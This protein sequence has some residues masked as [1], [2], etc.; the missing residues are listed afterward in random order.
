[1]F[2]RQDSENAGRFSV[3]IE[4]RYT[5]FSILMPPGLICLRLTLKLVC[6]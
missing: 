3:T 5:S 4:K 2:A 6:V 1:V